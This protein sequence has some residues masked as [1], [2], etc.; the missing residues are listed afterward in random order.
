MK[1]SRT[2]FIVIFVLTLLLFFLLSC[3][4]TQATSKKPEV[5]ITATLIPAKAVTTVEDSQTPPPTVKESFPATSL[6]SLTPTPGA[7]T[8]YLKDWSEKDA[9]AL[10]NLI[11][12]YA[13]QINSREKCSFWSECLSTVFRTYTEAEEM[14]GLSIREALYR[15]PNSTIRDKLRWQLALTD[16]ITQRPPLPD[17]ALEKLLEEGLTQGRFNPLRLDSDLKPYG[18]RVVKTLL[19][20]NLFGDGQGN[21]VFLVTVDG[22]SLGTVQR[23][24]LDGY[25]AALRYNLNGDADIVK[26]E[27]IWEFGYSTSY[28]FFAEEL[29]GDNQPEL[30][31]EFGVVNGSSQGIRLNIFQ[32]RNNRFESVTPTGD[33]IRYMTDGD[34]YWQIGSTQ[35]QNLPTI[36]IVESAMAPGRII[37][38]TYSWGDGALNLTERIVRPFQPFSC[39]SLYGLPYFDIETQ[40]AMAD[41]CLSEWPTSESESLGPSYPD[42]LRFYRAMLQLSKSQNDA[43]ASLQAIINDPVNPDNLTVSRAAQAYIENFKSSLD[44]YRACQ[45]ANSIMDETLDSGDASFSQIVEKWGY[46]PPATMP[47][48]ICSESEAITMM[49]DYWNSAGLVQDTS[50]V[51]LLEQAG[52]T[53]QSQEVLDLNENGFDDLVAIVPSNSFWGTCFDIWVFVHYQNNLASDKIMMY[54]DSRESPLPEL[55]IETLKLIGNDLPMHIIHTK[56]DLLIFQISQNNKD[57]LVHKLLETDNVERYSIRRED[58]NV[59][60]FVFYDES[61]DGR[62]DYQVRERE[63]FLG[64]GSTMNGAIYEW[65]RLSQNFVLSKR[66]ADNPFGEN[67]EDVSIRVEEV[68]FD[69][70]NPTEAMSIL[71]LLLSEPEPDYYFHYSRPRLYYLLGLVYELLGEEQKALDTYLQLWEDYPDSAY[72]MM[73]REKIRRE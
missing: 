16:A 66:L 73:I 17:E 44:L 37:T 59:S 71:E 58:Q 67:L 20:E 33:S 27:S 2:A 72:I 22:Q 47:S 43:L 34:L 26:V 61:V 31:T 30:I 57:G 40:I 29:T 25:I 42:Y 11:D 56:S 45:A 13:R 14:L 3:S 24:G 63:V 6:S 1:E 15:Y 9:L 53:I 41:I 70:S 68:L 51:N 4:N 69:E 35:Y 5:N 21:Y 60:I 7:T 49:V 38:E 28:D 19:V 48:Q 50:I 54:C 65:S 46:F 8:N 36:Q 32:W 55:S 23:D 10:I 52:V 18:F 39:P 12:T 62:L 64:S